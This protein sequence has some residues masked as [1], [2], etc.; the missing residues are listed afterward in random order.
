MSNEWKITDIAAE[1]SVRTDSSQHILKHLENFEKK[2]QDKKTETFK[3]PLTGL[4]EILVDIF[5]QR[6]RTPDPSN[7]K[8]PAKR[9]R[10]Q[11]ITDTRVNATCVMQE[12]H[13]G[14]RANA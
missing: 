13:G 9:I 12:D 8:P 14:T 10:P 1:E 2:Q 11:S 6:N 4:T 3:S 7:E 5:K